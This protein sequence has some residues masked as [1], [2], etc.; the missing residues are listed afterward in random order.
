[1][2]LLSNQTFS[3]SGRYYLVIPGD[4]KVDTPYLQYIPVSDV[5]Y[6]IGGV[7]AALLLATLATSGL[8]RAH[9]FGVA[10]LASA[11]LMV[12][13]FL[14]GSLAV[15]TARLH[16]YQATL[17][18]NTCGANLLMLMAALLLSRWVRFLEGANSP[19]A[20]LVVAFVGLVV[21]STIALDCVG[22]PLV[23]YENPWYR[24]VGHVLRITGMSATLGTSII[25]LLVSLWKAATNTLHM[26]AETICMFSGFGLLCIWAS[27]VLA[28]TKL[29]PANVTGTSEV[30]F[31][32]LGMLPLGLLL[33]VWVAL[34]A[35]RLFSYEKDLPPT[36][37]VDSR[38]SK[39]FDSHYEYP[40]L[41]PDNEYS[42]PVRVPADVYRRGAYE[43]ETRAP[44]RQETLE[45]KIQHAILKYA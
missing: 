24:H 6:G 18:L 42:Y 27:F 41:P 38:W 12:S 15:N 34:N 21:L 20:S 11:C 31:Y 32:L 43:S 23:F 3:T 35:P 28:Q 25:G 1:M 39:R 14:R 5:A 36:Y 4:I 37:H 7:F 13:Q 17:I 44:E 33:L 40:S 2:S 19:F 16:M 45:D 26:I 22:V 10:T 9:M 30:A 8:A 29:P